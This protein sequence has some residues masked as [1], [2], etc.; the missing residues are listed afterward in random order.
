M[1]VLDVELKS[2]V[3]ACVSGVWL[4]TLSLWSPPLGLL[5]AANGGRVGWQWQI[6]ARV[7]DAVVSAL[8]DGIVQHLLYS[9]VM[10]RLRSFSLVFT[11][12]NA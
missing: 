9:E 4:K 1:V 10:Q 5:A 6:A 7:K 8:H 2:T 11:P 3:A 12:T